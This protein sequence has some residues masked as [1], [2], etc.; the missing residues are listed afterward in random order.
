MQQNPPVD[1]ERYRRF[2]E[3]IDNLPALPAIVTR[4]IQVVN[5]P[6]T[7]ADDAA[8]L[9]QKDPALTTKMLRLAN[10]AFY[11]IPRSISSVS[12]AVVILGFNTIRSLVLSA[13][14]MKMFST[15]REP[16]IDK[17]CFW[18][19]SITCAI[20]AKSIV[21]Q[22]ISVRMM[23]PE[24]AFCAGML[25]DIGKL[26]FSEFAQEDY[27]EVCSFARKNGKSL[28]EAEKEILGISHTDIG[29]ILADKWALPLD[30]EYALV[31]HHEPM[32]ADSLIDLVTTVHVANT[33]SHAIGMGLWENETV[34]PEWD[35]AR[36]ILRM[37]E[38][39]YEHLL[40]SL[41]ESIDKSREFIDIIK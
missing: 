30:L 3:Q 17:D 8:K 24:S 27:S 33:L 36:S 23:D 1:N 14:V 15:S 19:H 25:H 13:S 5:S 11:G 20:A 39:D 40:K 41:T 34:T 10:S 4:L 37:G 31:F 28:L 12:S 9:I 2:I 21:R 16:A 35:E 7:S 38:S 22:F 6:D 29:R 18:K 26:I 32:K